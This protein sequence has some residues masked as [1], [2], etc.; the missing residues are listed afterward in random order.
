MPLCKRLTVHA[1]CR[2][3]T[4][5]L[6]PRDLFAE[7][8]TEP[9]SGLSLNEFK[10]FGYTGANADAAAFPTLD[11][12][13]EGYFEV[14][15]MGTVTTPAVQAYIK[16]SAAGV[17]GNCIALDN[18][19]PGSGNVAPNIFPGTFLAAPAGGLAGRASI[20]N[21]ANGSNYTFE[22]TAA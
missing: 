1:W 13:R 2:T 21:S 12:T 8:R 15:E 9:S 14:I 4:H 19:D 17:P 6:T 3:T 22:P 7:T 10:N 20:I 11:R 16:H 5:A 18:M